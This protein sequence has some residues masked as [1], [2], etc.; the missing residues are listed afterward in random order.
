MQTK[1]QF[2]RSIVWMLVLSIGCATAVVLALNSWIIYNTSRQ[3]LVRTTE[4]SGKQMTAKTAQEMSI[5]LKQLGNVPTVMAEFHNRL[6]TAPY[7][8]TITSLAS[9][10]QSQPGEV[11]SA[12]YSYEDRYPPDPTRLPIVTRASYPNA[13]TVDDSY[14]QHDADQEWYQKAKK[15]GKL[16]ITEPYYDDGSVNETMVSITVPMYDPKRRFY[17]VAGVDVTLEGLVKRTSNLKILDEAFKDREF[18]MLVSEGGILIAHPNN[19]LL[20]R[21]GFAGTQLDTLPEG[22]IVGN[23]PSGYQ[24]ALINGQARY[25]FWD[26]V[27]EVN[28]RLI[29]SVDESAILA[30]LAGLRARAIGTTVLAIVLM[31]ALTGVLTFRALRP[32]REM[33]AWAKRASEGQGDLTQR[34]TIHRQDELGEFAT[35]FNRFMDRLQEMVQQVRQTSTQIVTISQQLQQAK[36]LI[37]QSS[38]EV[39]QQASETQRSSQHFISELQ[40]NVAAVTEFQKVVEAFARQSEATA[41]LVQQSAQ[42]ITELQQVVQEVSRGS[43]QTAHTASDGLEAMRQMEHGVEHASTQLQTASEQTH[44][45]AQAAATGTETLAQATDAVRRIADDVHHVEQELQALA[46]MSN[47]IGEIVRTIE[48]IAR[49]TNLLALNAAIEAARA[50]EAGRGFAV[51]AEEV[52]RLAE[53][54]ANATRDIQQIIQQVLE[55]TQGSLQALETTVRSVDAGVQQADTVQQ[56]LQQ[57]LSAVYQISTQVETAVEAMQSVA[58]DSHR[59]LAQI[60]SIAA[61]G[62]QTSAATEEMSAEMATVNQNMGQVAVIAADSA[63][64]SEALTR[65]SQRIH[66][67]LRSAEDLGTAITAQATRSAQASEAQLQALDAVQQMMA[68]LDAL[69]GELEQRLNLFKVDTDTPSLQVVDTARAA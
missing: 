12:Y 65:Q 37:T 18:A 38:H 22:K 68:Q 54:S 33:T 23:S 4:A 42:V 69:S 45:V 20:L 67:S 47:S 35:Y 61:I 27:P 25:L 48:E 5:Y 60:E 19:Q 53:R 31:S 29:M 57:V 46:A 49:Q 24:R 1:R 41:Q 2:N 9:V 30:P 28:W 8:T 56:Q 50:G 7:K 14:D 43:D 21:K 39:R 40:Q 3:T 11:V 59:T 36:Q 16:A 52:R 32:L 63:A 55:R 6:G 13:H 44:Q 66:D 17:G 62:E 26:T 10:L 34:L 64:Q 58:Q 51:V 15:T